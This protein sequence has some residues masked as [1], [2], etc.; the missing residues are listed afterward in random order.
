MPAAS[1]PSPPPTGTGI[2]KLTNCR[3]VIGHS[4]TPSDLFINSQTGKI[5]SPSDDT[6]IPDVTIDLHNRILS[7]GLIDCQLNGAFGFNF[8]S[9]TSPEYIKNI[10]TLNTK[11]IRTGITSYLPTLTS[12][13]PELYHSTLPHLGP[14]RPIPTPLTYTSSSTSTASTNEETDRTRTLTLIR[15]PHHGSESLGAHVE[16]PFLSP[17]QHG[18]HDLSVLR[19]ANSWQDLEQVYGHSNLTSGGNNIKMITI[20][21]ELGSITT[22]IPELVSCGIVVSLGHTECTFGSGP[23]RGQD[24]DAFV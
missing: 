24:G 22:L 6:L 8:S 7:P 20:A 19:S 21:P 18:I 4:L 9:F 12:Q 10:H 5:I 2:T 17:S 15:N 13:T 16:G 23:K 1:S 14:L 3:L 11:L